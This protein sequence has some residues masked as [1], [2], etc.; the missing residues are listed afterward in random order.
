[1]ITNTNENRQRQTVSESSQPAT[2]QLYTVKQFALAYPAFTESSLR[3]LIFKAGLRHSSKG[4]V[5]GNGLL[6]CGA[7]VRLGRRILIDDHAFIAWVRS[8][9]DMG[10]DNKVAC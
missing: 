7:I 3:N 2:P 8:R 4:E 10:E 9:A 5:T 1:M 6:E